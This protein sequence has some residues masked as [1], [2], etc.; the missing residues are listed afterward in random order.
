M[1]GDVVM[2]VYFSGMCVLLT[3]QVGMEVGSWTSILMNAGSIPGE[4]N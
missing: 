2:C 3:G 4:L 1:L